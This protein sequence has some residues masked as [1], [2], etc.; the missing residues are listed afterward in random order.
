M[1]HNASEPEEER[2]WY[3]YLTE[4]SFRRIMDR[5]MV[6]LGRRGVRSWLDNVE[7]NIKVCEDLD[8]QIDVW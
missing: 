1:L 4:I 2:S 6:T 5:A 8:G 3:Y 7:G